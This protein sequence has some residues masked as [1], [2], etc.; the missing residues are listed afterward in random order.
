MFVFMFFLIVKTRIVC[1]IGLIDIK[2]HILMFQHP[3]RVKEE[4]EMRQID[5]F[6]LEKEHGSAHD[7]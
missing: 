7:S 5:L 1:I 2:Q 3:A 6:R 4:P